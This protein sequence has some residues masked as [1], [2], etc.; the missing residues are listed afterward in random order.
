MAVN[1]ADVYKRG[2]Q[3]TASKENIITMLYDGAIKFCNLAQAAIDAK[4]YEEANIN[5]QKAKRIIGELI[6]TLDRRYPVAEDFERVY[7][8]IQD[9]LT[10]AN[11]KKE[12]EYLER[13]KEEIRGMRETWVEVIKQAKGK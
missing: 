9:L 13:A 11:V 4:N 12:K 2:Q 10:M 3:Q 7:N 6:A 5:I 8:Y 1:A